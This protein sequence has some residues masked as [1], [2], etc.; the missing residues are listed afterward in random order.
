ALDQVNGD[1][2]F[3]EFI[4]I[5]VAAGAGAQKHDVLEAL[6]APGDI[7]RQLCMVDHDD[8]GTVEQRRHVFGFDVGIEV[9]PHSGIA[10]LILP[11]GDL[12]ER[13]VSIDKNPAH[14]SSPCSLKICRAYDATPASDSTVC[15]KTLAPAVQSTCVASSSSLWLMPSLQGTN[16]MAA[17]IFVL[18]LQA[19]WPAPE[20]MRRFE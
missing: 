4:R 12:C 13:S 3:G 19:S 2:E 7:R 1:A 10:G 20:V 15:I 8:L 18:R 6:A 14:D 17:G 11:L 9:D 5:H 16:T